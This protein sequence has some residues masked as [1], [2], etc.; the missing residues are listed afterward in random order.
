MTSS[1][2]LRRILVPHDFSPTAQAALDYALDLGEKVGASVTIVHA[3]EYPILTYPEGPPVTPELVGQVKH[4]AT[5]AL[6]ALV[7]RS[8][9]PGVAV[10][11]VLREGTAWHE[12]LGAAADLA[13]DLV[14]VGT[15]GRR[16]ISRALL[17]SVAEKI[18]R[19][20]RCPVLTV[21]GPATD[22]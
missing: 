15:H 10:D 22:T 21:H 17:G 14:V 20:A 1:F 3:Y 6:D 19:A 12:I 5:A 16:G 8:R 2:Q 9:R 13:V 18:V 4:A 11:G 7:Q